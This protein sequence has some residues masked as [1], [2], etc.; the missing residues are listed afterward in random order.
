LTTYVG[1]VEDAMSLCVMCGMQ[2]AA[3]ACL[4]P[5]HDP[6]APT[7]WA[8]ENR[9]MCDFLHRGVVP[10]RLNTDERLDDFVMTRHALEPR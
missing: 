10:R 5:Q 8:L 4:C 1:R 2:L 3:D 6:T 7:G 9:I